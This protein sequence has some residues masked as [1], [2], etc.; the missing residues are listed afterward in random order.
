MLF[1][2]TQQGLEFL[3]CLENN[4]LSSRLLIG[5][6]SSATESILTGGIHVWL[7]NITAEVHKLGAYACY[8]WLEQ[9]SL[10][11]PEG[12]VSPS[13]FAYLPWGNHLG[14]QGTRQSP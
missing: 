4:G 1:K 7:G 2:K 8:L 3:R 5:F 10:Q 13:L 6:Y 12:L 14:H 9:G 11:P